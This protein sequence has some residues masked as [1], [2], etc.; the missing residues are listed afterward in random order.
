MEVC[1]LIWYNKTM[2]AL[3][4]TLNNEQTKVYRVEVTYQKAQSKKAAKPQSR[5]GWRLLSALPLPHHTFKEFVF[6][7]WGG[8]CSG[9]PILQRKA[10]GKSLCKE[11]NYNHLKWKWGHIVT[12]L[13]VLNLFVLNITSQ[14]REGWA[15]PCRAVCPVSARLVEKQTLRAQQLTSLLSDS[16]SKTSK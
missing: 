5:L 11:E 7:C 10:N 13:E 2:K 14:R 9:P 8:R 16:C 12:K 6:L 1:S 4:C 15:H 3:L